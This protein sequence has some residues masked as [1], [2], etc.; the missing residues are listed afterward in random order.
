MII[1]AFESLSFT[2]PLKKKTVSVCGSKTW[3]V[4][5]VIWGKHEL[6]LCPIFLME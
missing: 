6:I 3:A 1:L 2:Q 4:I 5:S